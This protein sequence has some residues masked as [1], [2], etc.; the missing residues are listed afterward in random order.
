LRLPGAL[1]RWGRRGALRSG[2]IDC[3]VR[4]GDS[5]GTYAHP[6]TGAALPLLALL[7]SGCALFAAPRLPP[8]A[9]ESARRLTPGPYL[10]ESADVDFEDVARERTLATTIWWPD[11]FGGPAPLVVQV[12]GFLS[13]RNGAAYLARHLASHGYVVVAA[14]HPTTTLFA[15]GGAK[16]EDVV[17]QPGDLSF[18]IDRLLARGGETSDLPAVD[19]ARIA[20]MG[21]SLGGLTA[22]LAAFHP[23]LRDPRIAA[24]ISIAGPMEPLKRELFRTADVPFLM[25]AGS[26]DV[27]VDYRRNAFVVLDRVP[28]GMLVLLAGASHGG[29]DDKMTGLPRLLDN[30]DTLACWLLDRTLHLESALAKL[31]ADSRDED[32]IDLEHGV[33]APCAEEPISVAMDP[34]R[35]Q[36]ITTLAVTAFLEAQ[37]A[38]AAEV[39]ERALHYLVDGLPRDFEEVAVSSTDPGPARVHRPK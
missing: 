19:P 39:R 38:P 24:A 20:V 12:H 2:R 16:L 28:G 31:R 21:H 22:T 4:S 13:N 35:Q 29:F 14:T 23:R 8:P 6:G 7:V 37:L 34:A 18:L 26:G 15:P 10:V 33:P 27:I 36:V 17:R 1:R 9:S 3:P 11:G 32:G 25:I 5:L 30:P